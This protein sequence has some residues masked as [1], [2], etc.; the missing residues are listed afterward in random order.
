M[1]NWIN[2]FNNLPLMIDYMV[3]SSP[4][5]EFENYNSNFFQKTWF[6]IRNFLVSFTRDY[7]V[8]VGTGSASEEEEGEQTDT[9]EPVLLKAWVS[10][11]KE[12]AEILKQLSDEEFSA[13]NNIYIDYNMLPAGQLGTTGIMLLAVASGTEPD[14][15]IGSDQSVPTEYGMRGQVL[16]LSQFSDYDEVASALLPGA[17]TPYK[18]KDAVYALPET[19]DFSILY[20][21][22]DIMAS[23]NLQV[24][25][26][27]EELYS[28]ILPELKRNG[29][30]FWYDSSA[31]AGG[32]NTLLFQQGGSL[33]INDDTQSGIG[34]NLGYEAFKQFCD[35]YT[36]YKV[37]VSANF[38]NRFRAGQMP[39][40]VSSFQLY[41]QL[42]SAAPEL[43]GKW[44][45]TVL[46]A[47]ER[48]DGTK[49]RSCVVNTTSCMIFKSTE[50][51]NE[52]WEYLKWYT[53]AD[54]QIRYANDIVAYI[55]PEARWFSSNMEA[56][57]TLSWDK[58]LKAAV[59]EQRDYCKGVPNVIGGYITARHQE[60]ARVRS[61]VN[62][63]NY[64][65]SLERAVDDINRELTVKNEEFVLRAEKEAE[66]A[67]KAAEQEGR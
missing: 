50:H 44:A 65:E 47:T 8:I 31:A 48:E 42:T 20:Y 33:Y 41:L 24:P 49:D 64:R 10:R 15:V 45:A 57:D 59:K 32:L 34:T 11:G 67:A 38:Y 54:T 5:N 25:D 51:P 2:G 52:A 13:N 37:P 29:M 26:T 23:L 21:R 9:S 14:L 22:T 62:G 17:I 1:S 58:T 28:L 18:F 66:K 39:I 19:I 7:D 53:S 4:E 27:W 56:F 61:V 12:W 43:E 55:G 60:N 30:D 63:M 40:G 6:S 46:P 35:L 16:D 3:V 36:V